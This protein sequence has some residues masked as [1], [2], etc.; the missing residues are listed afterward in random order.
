M[1]VSEPAG[2]EWRKSSYSGAG[3]DCIEIDLSETGARV[4]D[5]KNPDAGILRFG[6]AGW[7]PF[8]QA[9]RGQ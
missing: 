8:I 1:S 6:S 4:R 3:N 5:S 7:T 2:A 9:T